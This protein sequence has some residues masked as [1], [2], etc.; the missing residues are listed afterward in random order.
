MSEE[1][2]VICNSRKLVVEP[3]GIRVRPSFKQKSTI[4]YIKTDEVSK[5]ASRNVHVDI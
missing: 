2:L 1:E 4:D 5:K 3:E